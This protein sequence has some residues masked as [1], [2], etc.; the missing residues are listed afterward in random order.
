M[1]PLLPLLLNRFFDEN[2]SVVMS[3]NSTFHKD[4]VC[5]RDYFHYGKFLNG[6]FVAAHSS[7]HRPAFLS[8]AGELAHPDR[9]GFTMEVRTV[10]F[11]TAAE[12]ETLHNALKTFTDRSSLNI[13]NIAFGE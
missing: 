10:G 13:H 7:G 3:R 11:R 12:A 4:K 9:T 8:L 6:Y 1:M 2:D 5:L